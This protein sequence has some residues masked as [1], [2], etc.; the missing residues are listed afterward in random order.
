MATPKTVWGIDIGQVALKAIKLRN[1]D[2]ELK[3]EAFDIIEHPRIL[4]QPDVD[5]RQFIRVALEQFL[6]RNNVSNSVVAVAVPGQ[7]SFAVSRF[8][9][10]IARL[11]AKMSP[12]QR[13]ANSWRFE[14]Q[15]RLT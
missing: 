12:F 5:R 3:V 15:P 6:A 11:S 8:F 4:S 9:V 10:F 7:S 2:G 13:R 14:S 1:A